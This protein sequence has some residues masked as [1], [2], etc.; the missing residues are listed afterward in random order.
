MLEISAK[1]YQEMEGVVGERN[2]NGSAEKSGN[3]IVYKD[4]GFDKIIW[5]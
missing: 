1:G 4:M 3:Q 5:I 2:W